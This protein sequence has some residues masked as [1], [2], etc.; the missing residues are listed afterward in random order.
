MFEIIYNH[1]SDQS[2][3]RLLMLKGRSVPDTDV[4]DRVQADISSTG[5]VL[6]VLAHLDGFQPVIHRVHTELWSGWVLPA[7]MDSIRTTQSF[8][9]MRG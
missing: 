3:C 1:R 7:E 4:E 6:L 2:T 8:D 9:L 5:K